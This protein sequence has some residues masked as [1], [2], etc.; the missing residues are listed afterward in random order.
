MHETFSKN[1]KSPITAWFTIGIKNSTPIATSSSATTT[2]T[3]CCIGSF[4]RLTSGSVST[5]EP[6]N[7]TTGTTTLI[8]SS[9]PTFGNGRSQPP[10]KSVTAT[11]DT[12]KI[13][14]YSAR[15]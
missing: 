5:P 10:Q 9:Q 11:P 4:N 13:L 12:T 14:A 8:G 15:K 2:S 6:I 7:S 3:F 1:Q